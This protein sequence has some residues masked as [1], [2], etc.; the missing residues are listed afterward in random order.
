MPEKKLRLRVLINKGQHTISLHKLPKI[1][2]DIQK[3]LDSLSEDTIGRKGDWVGLEFK[4]TNSI[5][6]AAEKID[7]VEE[8]RINDFNACLRGVVG[9]KPDPKL[10]QSTLAQYAQI[11][12]PGSE[13]TVAFG[14][15]D[16]QGAQQAIPIEWL[17]VSPEITA[18]LATE[19][20]IVRS[21]G[22]VQ[23][24]MHS[25][26]LGTSHFY[27]RELSSQNLVKCEYDKSKYHEIVEAL[28][29]QNAVLHVYGTILTDLADRKIRSLSVSHIE[30]ASVLSLTDLNKF[31]GS[32]AGI[33][34][35]DDLQGLIDRNRNRG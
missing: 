24:V 9:G 8:D 31:I 15:G 14:L 16:E 34:N 13:E 22:S 30:V 28:E 27:L 4:S 32:T 23:G 19:A 10:R 17:S 6:Y 20:S 29:T 2:T 18:G 3:F 26:Y 11:V 33:I 21:I 1:L 25:L 5:E 35:T 7:P 12:E